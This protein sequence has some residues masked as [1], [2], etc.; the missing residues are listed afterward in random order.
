MH[1]NSFLAAAT[2]ISSR[3]LESLRGNIC[4][5][6]V[7]GVALSMY[8]SGLNSLE[9]LFQTPFESDSFKVFRCPFIPKL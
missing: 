5:F 3:C 1:S 6:E 4:D 9:I 8:F 7:F 2:K